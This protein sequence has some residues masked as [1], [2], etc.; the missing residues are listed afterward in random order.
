MRNRRTS[1]LD[2]Q[3][4]LSAEPEGGDSGMLLLLAAFGDV[5]SMFFSHLPL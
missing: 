1:S 2:R 4:N 3:Q 5:D